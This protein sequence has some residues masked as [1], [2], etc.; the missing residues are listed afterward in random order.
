MPIGMLFRV[1][2]VIAC[3]T[4]TPVESPAYSIVALNH[5]LF[6]EESARFRVCMQQGEV[7]SREARRRQRCAPTSSFAD[8]GKSERGGI[9]RRLFTNSLSAHSVLKQ[10]GIATHNAL[11]LVMSSSLLTL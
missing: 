10:G 11:S 8:C 1:V 5:S 3:V 7:L 2:E 4:W 6:Q 9:V